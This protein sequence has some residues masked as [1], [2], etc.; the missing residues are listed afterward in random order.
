MKYRSSQI[1]PWTLIMLG[2]YACVGSAASLDHNQAVMRPSLPR[3]YVDTT[4]IPPSGRKLTVPSDGDLQAALDQAQ[5]GDEIVLTAGAR[6]KG[7]FTLPNKKEG[8]G[9]IIIRSS[10]VDKD[11]PRP[12]SR[13]GPSQTAKMATL[14][15]NRYGIILAER[16][17]HHFRFIGIEMKS[18][19]GQ[20]LR[21]LVLLGDNTE[22][23]VDD[24]PHHIIIDRCYLHAD[25][26]GGA[27]RGV[28]MN[29]RHLAVIDSCVVGFREEGQDSQA[30]AG[31]G[32][33]GPFKVVNNFLQAAGENLLFG[34][35]DPSVR[36][37]V[38]SDIE[39]RRNH[40]AKPLSWK[41]GEPE[42][43]GGN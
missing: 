42:H 23:S 33:S 8:S 3:E 41:P 12:G 19:E 17:A 30:V 27:R 2:L 40:A 10:A 1:L 24:L 7:P 39:I 18:D 26:K 13:V 20:S 43:D 28:V 38:P 22:G 9:W 37:L 31:W 4:L 29:G 5:L 14:V 15:S 25:P 32:G 34:G 16:K 35:G 36:N 11:F 6:Y 21:D